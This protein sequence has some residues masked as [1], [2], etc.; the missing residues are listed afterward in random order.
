[1]IEN[2]Q[3]IRISGKHWSCYMIPLVGLSIAVALTLAKLRPPG[4]LMTFLPVRTVRVAKILMYAE[5]AIIATLAVSCG[6]K[7]VRLTSCRYILTSKRLVHVIN[8]NR[9]EYLDVSNIYSASL[10]R[11][12]A[13]RRTRGWVAKGDIIIKSTVGTHVLSDVSHPDEFIRSIEEAHDGKTDTAPTLRATPEDNRPD[14]GE[15]TSTHEEN[16]DAPVKPEAPQSSKDK[17]KTENDGSRAI[18]DPMAALDELTGLTSVKDEVRSLRNFITVQK[19][20]RERGIPV[21]D[22]SLHTVFTGNPGTG[23]T[24]VARIMAAIYRDTGLLPTGKLV[25]MDRSGLVAEYVGQTAVKTNTA[26]DRAMGGVLFIDEA[27]AL[28]EGGASDYGMEAVTT[29]LKRMED[30][31]GRFAVILAGYTDNMSDFMESNPGLKS[32]F[33]RTIHFPDYTAEELITIYKTM[34]TKNGYTLSADGEKELSARLEK[35]VLMKDR[36]FGNARHVRNLFERSIQ[37]QADRVMRMINP[38]DWQ[39]GTITREDLCDD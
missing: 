17:E 10:S 22:I 26:I 20:R 31:R 4:V 1:M 13:T 33:N 16:I 28:T 34:A 25:E 8:S 24:T 38:E 2:E 9:A 37:R 19:M 14:F 29:L 35:D 18:A 27:Y 11:R 15:K 23:K 21:A 5:W 7:L 39:L 12:S 36:K 6:V 32:R 30:D 3:T